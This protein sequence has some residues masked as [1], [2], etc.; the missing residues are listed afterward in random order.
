[1][2]N[3][4]EIP[5]KDAASIAE[6]KRAEEALRVERDFNAALVEASPAFL[7]TIG[8]DGRIRSMNRA[9]LQALGYALEEVVGKDY[10]TT[11]VGEDE[12]PVLAA[13]FARLTELREP[14]LNE[15]HV[16]TKDGR[17]I[18]VEWHGRPILKPDG[19]LCGG[20]MKCWKSKR[21][22]LPAWRA[23]KPYSAETSKPRCRKSPKL[24]PAL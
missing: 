10:L 23:V 9:M 12:R 4:R 3:S 11:V 18:L 7:V 17:S 1:M 22:S 14:T 21:R 19:E 16:L 8:G 6:Q 15:N 24:P 13:V 20:A 5:G 2:K